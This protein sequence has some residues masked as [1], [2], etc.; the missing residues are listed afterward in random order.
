M[1]SCRVSSKNPF[2]DFQAQLGFGLGRYPDVG[3]VAIVDWRWIWVLWCQAEIDAKDGHIELDCPLSGVVLMLGR[4]CDDKTAAV[5][6]NDRK[7][8]FLRPMASNG[9][10]MKQADFYMAVWIELG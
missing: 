8:K 9:L 3:L 5:E 7:I 10:V 2:V 4:F 6:M 1:S